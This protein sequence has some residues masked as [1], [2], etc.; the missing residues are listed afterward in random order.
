MASYFAHDHSQISE[1]SAKHSSAKTRD[2]APHGAIKYSRINENLAICVHAN[3]CDSAS[4]VAPSS[5]RINERW[6][7]IH[8][9]D[10]TSHVASNSSQ[11]NKNS[12]RHSQSDI[13]FKKAMLDQ[14]KLEKQREDLF[15]KYFGSTSKMPITSESSAMSMKKMVCPLVQ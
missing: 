6:V 1:I 5:S 2:S 14:R 8:T 13:D 15:H 7:N 12:A 11:I 4:Y 10:S 9:H 3:S